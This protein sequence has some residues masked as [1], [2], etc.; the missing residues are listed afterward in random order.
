LLQ[1]ARFP[2]FTVR[3]VGDGVAALLKWIIRY[4]PVSGTTG[5]AWRELVSRYWSW[6]RQKVSYRAFEEAVHHAFERGMAWVF[7]TCRVLTP[8]AALLVIAA[9]V[10]WL[11]VSFVAAT[12][13]HAV[14]I[15]KAAS[16]PAWMQLLHVLATVVAKSKLLVLPVYPVAWPQAKKHAVVQAMSQFYRYV[17][18]LHLMQKAEY[19]YRQTDRA[20]VATADSLERAAARVGLGSLSNALFAVRN[21]LATRKRPPSFGSTRARFELFSLCQ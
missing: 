20:I 18:S 16:L 13:V 10:L 14:L 4:L 3:I 5:D 15:A 2:L 12:V 6:L 21:G 9:A 11:P 17:T 19:R 7:R 8:G 1:L